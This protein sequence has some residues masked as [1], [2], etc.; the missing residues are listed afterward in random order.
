MQGYFRTGYHKK[1]SCWS[2]TQEAAILFWGVYSRRKQASSPEAIADL[3]VHYRPAYCGVDIK[4]RASSIDQSGLWN[5]I[6]PRVSKHKQIVTSTPLSYLLACHSSEPGMGYLKFNANRIILLV[7][8]PFDSIES[9]FHMGMTNTHDKTLSREVFISFRH[10]NL[11]L[12]TDLT[13]QQTGLWKFATDLEP[14]RDEWSNCVGCLPWV[15]A[16]FCWQEG[17]AVAREIRRSCL[18]QTC[19]YLIRPVFDI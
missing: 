3:I 18:W 1:K 11:H 8:N 13:L 12:L 14:M 5:L 17:P 19:Q 4:G 2:A 10:R 7:R 16:E 6:I 9:Y 15:L